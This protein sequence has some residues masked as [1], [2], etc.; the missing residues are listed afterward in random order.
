[1]FAGASLNYARPAADRRDAGGKAK[2]RRLA[3]LTARGW[4]RPVMLFVSLVLLIGVASGGWIGLKFYLAAAKITHNHNPFSLLQVFHPVPL[5]SQGGRVNILIGGDSSD[6]QNAQAN[7]GDLTDSIM[8]LSIDTSNKTGMMISIPRDTWVQLPDSGGQLAGTHQKI[9]AA[10]TLSNFH[11]SGY[12]NGGMGALEYV[13]K[14]NFGVPIDYYALVNYQAF[15]DLVNAVG[16]ITIT[17]QSPDPRGLYDPQ[18]FPGAKVLK[19]PNGPVNL[20]GLEALNLARARGEAAG[21]YGF[22]QSDF[23][24]TEHQRE[25]AIAIKDKATSA[26]VISNPLKIGDLAGAVGNNVQTDMKLDE[27]ESFYSLIKNVPDTAIQ[28]YN[29][30]TL[31]SGKYLLKTYITPSGQD[32]LAPATGPDDFS[33][34]AAALQRLLSTDPV[35]QENAGV[36]VLNGGSINGLARTEGTILAG[37]GMNVL[38]EA[39]AAQ[40]YQTT[41]IIDNSAGKFPASKKELQTLFGT[42]VATDAKLSAKYPS[43]AFI[44]ILGANQQA[45]ASSTTT[46]ASNSNI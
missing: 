20:N 46:A 4:K 29:I 23:N 32:A 24:R 10:N 22:P 45:P 28:S 44:V 26:S 2:K 9:N 41:T 42:N 36:V 3:W 14:Q 18:P 13:I 16:G 19:L 37:K 33:E 35:V 43:A 6:R 5:K 15:Q 38:T 27:V 40:S 12:P 1:M 39:T 25:M 7:G 17:I 34:I 31:V 11:A 21:S 8:I 30:N